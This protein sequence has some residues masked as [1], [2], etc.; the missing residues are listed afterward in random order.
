M[1][2]QGRFMS[3][4]SRQVIA[5]IAAMLD[6]GVD[7]GQVSL[8]LSDVA[9]ATL[10]GRSEITDLLAQSPAV[11]EHL[12]FEITED[13][14]I[15]R[16]AETIQNSIAA[17]RAHGVRISLDDFGTGFA[18]FHHLR[19]L[20]FDE[21]KIDTTFVAGLG[22]DPTADVLVRGFL[23]IASGLGVSV[24]AE[25]VE[26]E[27]QRQ[28][29]INMGCLTAQGYLFLSA[30]PCDRAITLLHNQDAA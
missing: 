2:L 14:F 25:G 7:P 13:V 27:Q 11:T 29:L 8:N 24:V 28:D 18:S 17:F 15:G 12:T 4:M 21:L 3:S 16:A 30:V 20:E 22:H 9:L 10:P 1:G 23:D 26:T 6:A 19:Q 5:D